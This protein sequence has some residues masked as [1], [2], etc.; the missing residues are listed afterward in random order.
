[1][2]LLTAA[3]PVLSLLALAASLVLAMGSIPR[4]SR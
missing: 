2:T 4:R 1:V 3:A